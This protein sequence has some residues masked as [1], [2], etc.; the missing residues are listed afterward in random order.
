MK[1]FLCTPAYD[2][3]VHR[4]Y[5]VSLAATCHMLIQ[6]GH[7]VFIN[8]SSQSTLLV[9][10]RNNF[11]REFLE[12]ECTHI[13][14]VDSDLG[15]NPNELLELMKFDKDILSGVYPSRKDRIFV[16]NPDFKEDGKSFKTDG[17]LVKANFVPAGFIL[18]KRGAIE[19]MVRDYSH[20]AYES[21]CGVG[22][23]GTLL[24][25]T[26]VIDG[27]FWSEDYVFFKRAKESAL[28]VWMDPRMTF[29]HAGSVA[30]LHVL[31]EFKE[32]LEN[33]K[34]EREKQKHAKLIASDEGYY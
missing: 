30:G 24:F 7:E 12:T 33:F 22:D 9:A 13:L 16:Y 19:K 10:A 1:I 29:D 3:K 32:H 23:K 4:Q 31:D 27:E 2:G 17:V 6:K 14:M 21:K 18:M 20:L 11:I 26:E 28:E 34:Q 8:L 5:A 25:N 15:W